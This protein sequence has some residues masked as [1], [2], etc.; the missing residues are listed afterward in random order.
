MEYFVDYLI[1]DYILLNIYD[2]N[3]GV[4]DGVDACVELA[5]HILRF[6]KIANEPCDE[7]KFRKMC[8]ECRWFKLSYKLPFR[9]Y[10]EDGK[11]TYYG[12]LISENEVR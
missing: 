11:L 7:E 12:R 6:E 4:K 5:P 9:E 3:G 1:V 10:T 8:E 2:H